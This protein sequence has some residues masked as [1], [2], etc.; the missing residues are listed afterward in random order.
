MKTYIVFL[1]ALSLILVSGVNGCPGGAEKEEAAKIAGLSISFVDNA[2]PISATVN[3]EFPIYVDVLNEGGDYVNKGGAKFYLSGVGP[4]LEGVKPSL[5]NEDNLAKQ[6]IS[7]YR[8][9]FA[10]RAKFTEQ[11]PS[12]FTLPLVLTT[13]YTYGTTAQ[14]SLCLSA[15]NDS[16]VCDVGGEKIT[17]SSNSVAPIQITSLKEELTGNRLRITFTIENKLDG[18]V[19]LK[20]T[21]CDKLQS[22]SESFKKDKVDV[23]VRIHEREKEGFSCKLLSNTPPYAPTDSL[24]GSAS[25]GTVVCEKTLSGEENYASPLGIVLRYKYVQSTSK[26]INIVP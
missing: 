10:D 16:R 3:Q 19:Y 1:I 26:A 18:Q 14:A 23:E 6:S 4:S 12:L 5:S 20:D 24:V 22:I 8:I 21:D 7:P 2:P 13:C 9:V 25:L 17:S 11:I 15:K